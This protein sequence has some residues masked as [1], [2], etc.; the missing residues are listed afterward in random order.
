VQN[1]HLSYEELTKVALR[2][3]V[4]KERALG[5][6]HLCVDRDALTHLVSVD[7]GDAHNYKSIRGSDPDATLFFKL[8]KMW[9]M[10]ILG[11]CK[12]LL[13]C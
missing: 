1:E 10:L 9:A 3:V 7:A 13:P 11:R 5:N 2:A 8:R 4:D 6:S 12:W